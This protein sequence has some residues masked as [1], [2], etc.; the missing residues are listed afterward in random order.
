MLTGSDHSNDS[1]LILFALSLLAAQRR[2][3]MTIKDGCSY[4][5]T[6]FDEIQPDASAYRLADGAVSS[7]S[8]KFKH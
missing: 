6:G 8:A 2:I 7:L 5:K 1:V 4:G 3:P